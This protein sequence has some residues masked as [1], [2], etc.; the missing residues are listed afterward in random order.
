MELIKFNDYCVKYSFPLVIT[1]GAFD[2]IH[3]GHQE[4][5]KNA[6]SK[7]KKLNYKSAVITFNPHPNEIISKEKRFSINSLE[8]KAKIIES[9][10]VDYLIII[11][12]N[13]TFSKISK[14][15]F[16]NNYLLKINVKEV[17]VG[18]DF[19]FGHHGEG[20]A[21]EISSLSDNKINSTIIDIVKYENE[22]IGSTKIIELL[23]SGEI[24]LVNQLLGYEYFFTGKVIK[25]KQIGRQLGFP[26]AN[27]DNDFARG[28]LK[29]GVY[30]VNVCIDDKS[31]LGMM[32]VGHNPTCNFTNNISIEI[33]LFDVD[34]D[35]YDK[36]LK[37]ECFCY[38][39]GEIKFNSKE[40]LI[41]RL[42]CD[43]E[44]IINKNLILAKK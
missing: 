29:V 15:E 22:K 12:F 25:G 30:G 26:T 39:R 43:K 13:D 14:K 16:I 10:G 11:E 33:N 7:S 5:I 38:V 20:N 1:I 34:L 6:V 3:L 37:I 23:K 35:L 36:I 2:G 8:T 41:E 28:L 32:N 24:D 19:K 31:Y 40:E 4:L 42:K 17:I 27:I 18:T 21:Y 44:I 9:F